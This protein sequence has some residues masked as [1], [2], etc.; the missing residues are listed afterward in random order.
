MTND[1]G[2]QINGC[3]MQTGDT[4]MKR[5]TFSADNDIRFWRQTSESVRRQNLTYKIDP[6]NVG[7]KYF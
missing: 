6:G 7:V 3:S 1:S 5:D 4:N 2:F